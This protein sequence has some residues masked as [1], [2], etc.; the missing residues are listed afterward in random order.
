M[1]RI[2]MESLVVW[3]NS[4]GRKPLIVQG[5]RQVGKTY[6]LKAFGKSYFQ[7]FHYINFEENPEVSTVFQKSL[8]PHIIVRELEFFL[9]DSIDTSKD[10]IIFDEIQRDSKALISLKYFNEKMPHAAV[11][12]AGSL[13]GVVMG[14]DSFPVGKVAFLDLYPMSFLEFIWAVA[15]SQLFDLLKNHDLRKPFPL[16]A[17]GKF[18]E[19]WKHYLIVGGLPEAVDYYL[20]NSGD[21]YNSLKVIRQMQDILMRTY[22]ADMA[23]HSGKINSV[24]IE[25]VFRSVPMQLA[26]TINGSSKRFILKEVVPGIRGYARLAS[27]IGWLERANL[28]LRIPIIDHVEVPLA[29]YAKENIFK[30]YF[31]DVGLL[32]SVSRLSPSQ[33]IQYDFS[34]YKGF[35]AENFVAQEFATSSGELPYCWQ[36]RTSEVEF[37]IQASSGSIIPVEVKAGSVTH[38][39]SLSVYTERN[40]P[41]KSIVVSARNDGERVNRWYIPLYAAGRLSEC[42]LSL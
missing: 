37:L 36:R 11:C 39:K 28:L 4:K 30:L 24:H 7:K 20:N 6:L 13:L 8:D 27:P 9:G 40:N 5:A 35:F 15:D 33:I 25:Q 10:L 12:V 16:L 29:A 23:K 17:H 2:Q 38:S 26:R 41:V 14:G 18:M 31:F 32:G 21:L 19:Y 22:M 1:D 42:V 34:T 3:K